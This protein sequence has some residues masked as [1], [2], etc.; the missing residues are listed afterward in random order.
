[1]KVYLAGPEVFFKNAKI[2]FEQSKSY[3]IRKGLIPLSPFDAVPDSHIQSGV[4]TAFR[5]YNG[6]IGLI[7]EADVVIANL[8]CFRGTEPDSG[9]V[10]E[11]GYAVALGKRVIA[12]LDNSLLYREKV[13]QTMKVERDSTGKW[14]DVHESGVEDMGLQLN[15]MLGCSVECVVGGIEEALNRA[16]S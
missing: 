7:K 15:L 14:V 13:A 11:V 10:F 12:Y 6:N 8:N 16:A 1:L 5:I 2:L 3:A 4:G 9:T